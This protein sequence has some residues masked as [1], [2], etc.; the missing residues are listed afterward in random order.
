MHALTKKLQTVLTS[1]IASLLACAIISVAIPVS[2]DDTGAEAQKS[3]PKVISLVHD[4]NPGFW[5][6]RDIS[7]KIQKDVEELIE[8]R[9]LSKL[10][11]QQL[12]IKVERLQL[13][14][15]IADNSKNAATIATNALNKAVALRRQ[16]EEDRDS[17]F[18]GKPWF[19]FIAG[20]VI[21]IAGVVTVA[22]ISKD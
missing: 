4:G 12:T 3:L 6:P 8:L 2:A 22:V 17:F 10:Q 9:K 13:Q 14:K 1:F 7:I 21:G 18:S 16:A 19:W 15:E 20:A 5:Y 11:D